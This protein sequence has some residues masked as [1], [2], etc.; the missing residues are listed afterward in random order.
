MASQAMPTIAS[1]IRATWGRWLDAW[2]THQ[3][4]KSAAKLASSAWA[5]S[6][7]LMRHSQRRWAS[8]ARSAGSW[9]S[10]IRTIG[11]AATGVLVDVLVGQVVG[12]DGEG[13]VAEAEVAGDLEVALGHVGS[14]RGLVVGD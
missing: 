4:P 8:A 3:S 2:A 11:S 13:A 10:P 5:S 7:A 1:S 14:D 9:T 6:P 12:Q